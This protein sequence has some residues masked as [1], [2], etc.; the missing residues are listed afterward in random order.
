MKGQPLG[1]WQRLAT[2]GGAWQCFVSVLFAA[3]LDRA[4]AGIA[5]VVEQHDACTRDARNDEASK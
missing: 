4:T 1:V 2:S 3:E 5:G